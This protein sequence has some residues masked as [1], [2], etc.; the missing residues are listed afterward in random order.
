MLDFAELNS[1]ARWPGASVRNI[2]CNPFLASSDNR[3]LLM[4]HGIAALLLSF[5]FRDRYKKS[6]ARRC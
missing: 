5:S 3:Q 6:A 4:I 2:S 1:R